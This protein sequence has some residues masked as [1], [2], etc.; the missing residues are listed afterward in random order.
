MTMNIA[1]RLGAGLLAGIFLTMLAGCQT[2]QTQVT[3]VA[4]GPTYP[5]TDPAQVQVLTTAPAQAN[6]RLG[7]VR[8]QPSSGNM[9]KADIEAA[10]QAGA[11]KLGADAV[12]IVKDDKKQVGAPVT[13]AWYDQSLDAVDQR[14]IVGEAIKYTT[15]PAGQTVI[16]GTAQ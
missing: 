10:L 6:V 5:P 3:P 15:P 7:Q 11:A 1:L 4:A 9:A 8:V 13:G 12:V 16:T 14:I 2:V